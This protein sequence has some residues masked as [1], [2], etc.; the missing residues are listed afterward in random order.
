MFEYEIVHLVFVG[1]HGTDDLY[2]LLRELCVK[3][4]AVGKLIQFYE[5]IG[6]GRTTFQKLKFICLRTSLAIAIQATGPGC[7]L[8]P[9]NVVV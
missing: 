6:H 9:E 1:S 3:S 5:H 4:A 8:S 7:T 2:V